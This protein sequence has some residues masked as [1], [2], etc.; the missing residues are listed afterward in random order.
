MNPSAPRSLARLLRRYPAAF[1]L[2][3]AALALGLVDTFAYQQLHFLR[4][5]RAIRQRDGE[6]LS[7]LLLRGPML[8]EDAQR[9]AAAT[10]RIDENLVAETN[11][12]ENLWYFY[13]IEEETR[14]RLSELRQLSAPLADTGSPYRP[15]PYTLRLTGTYDQ[16]TSFLQ[17]I[18]TGP[19]VA[20]I[21]SFTYS[22]V[23]PASPVVALDLA[24]SLLGRP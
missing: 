2:G 20:R 1:A 11:L 23:S 13:K 8:R 5:A 10:R 7:V 17:R 21:T 9:V 16:V 24:L 3:A 19:R 22:R 6:E 12:A 15:V 4:E 14:A 18:E